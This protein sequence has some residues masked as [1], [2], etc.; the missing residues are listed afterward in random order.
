MSTIHPPG[1]GGQY[2]GEWSG[3]P[4]RPF[5]NGPRLRKRRPPKERA[6]RE[7]SSGI[8]WKQHDPTKDRYHGAVAR[9]GDRLSKCDH[10]GES[11]FRF[12]G[13]KW[14]CVRCGWSREEVAAELRAGDTF[15]CPW[16]NEVHTVKNDTNPLLL[17]VECGGST[18][19]CGFNRSPQPDQPGRCSGCGDSYFRIIAGR[20]YCLRCWR[21]GSAVFYF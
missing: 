5:A 18:Y 2:G 15:K 10:C 7:S 4:P 20:G 19:P 14:Y 6:P 21:S 8:L 12:T 1:R 9:T 13:L 17:S 16:C 3:R 11:H